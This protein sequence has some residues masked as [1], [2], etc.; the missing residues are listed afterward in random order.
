MEDSEE[1]LDQSFSRE[2]RT[3]AFKYCE[4]HCG[5]VPAWS[6]LRMHIHVK[7]HAGQR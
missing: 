6:H 4:A 2:I 5:G 1:E 3:T 7:A